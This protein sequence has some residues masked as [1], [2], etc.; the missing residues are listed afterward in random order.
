M[1]MDEHARAWGHEFVN[2]ILGH[3]A[4]PT[5]QRNSLHWEILSHLHEAAERRVEARGGQTITL[6]DL[7][8]TVQELGGESKIAAAFLE[9]RVAAAPRAGF[10]KRAGAYV[11]DVALAGV[12]YGILISFYEVFFAFTRGYFWYAFEDLLGLLFLVAAYLYLV[13]SEVR[14]G[15]TIGKHVFRLRT[16]R[17]DGRPIEYRE[18]L[19]RNVAKVIPPLLLVDVV[20]YLLAF[21]HEDQRASDRLAD[22]IVID[23]AKPVWAP[24]PIPAAPAQVE[25]P[26]AFVP[27]SE[28]EPAPGPGP[29]H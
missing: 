20:L 17:I 10:W 15:Q 25:P 21:R 7:Q 9:N 16:V 26:A 13:L 5:E 6:T 14:Y 22:T 27:V 28:M 24:P 1:K 29:G 18:A 2:N 11:V 12:A 8:A 4:L 3:S 23:T 19:I